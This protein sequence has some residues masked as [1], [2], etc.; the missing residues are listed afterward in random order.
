[1]T[2][3]N[4]TLAS[5]L[6]VGILFIAISIIVIWHFEKA[7]IYDHS[8]R[9]LV[10]L[11][12]GLI[13]VA[14]AFGLFE[15]NTARSTEQQRR[16]ADEERLVISQNFRRAAL[17]FAF[18]AYQL[19]SMRLYCG[20]APIDEGYDRR[21]CRESAGLAMRVGGILPGLDF[22][23]N[24]V[25]KGSRRFAISNQ[26]ATVILDGDLALKGRMPSVIETYINAYTG[27]GGLRLSMTARARFQSTLS[28]LQAVGEAM[29]AM[30]CLF[31]YRIGQGWDEFDHTLELLDRSFAEGAGLEYKEI[32]R[33]HVAGI[34]IG[35]VKCE[36][37]RADLE[38]VLP[39]GGG[40]N[41]GGN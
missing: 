39:G 15:L 18:A 11:A 25:A 16:A 30:F 4:V 29:G 41:G 12:V 28:D 17:H 35:D 21:I 23:F 32:V 31:T 20:I 8:S 2:E 14:V 40:G 37:V 13:S 34:T 38:K 26:V 22:I 36:D 5:A 10:A 6:L 19:R 3:L 1:M 24:Q 9:T 27:I 7:R 33:E